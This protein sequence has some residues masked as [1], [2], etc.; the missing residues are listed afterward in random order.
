NVE[1][2]EDASLLAD[3]MLELQKRLQYQKPVNTRITKREISV[4]E[5]TSYIRRILDKRDKIYFNDLFEEYA[6][7]LIVA[8]F[9]S[10]LDMCKN[11]EITLKQTANFEDIYIE[12]VIV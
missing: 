8:T 12:K 7:D 3:A 6:K 11:K 1:G 9:L 10:I 2:G 5:R 4:E